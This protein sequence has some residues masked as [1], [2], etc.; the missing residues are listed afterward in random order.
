MRPFS[1]CPITIVLLS[2][3]QQLW[4]LEWSARLGKC[5]HHH[6]A[7]RSTK[8]RSGVETYLWLF[9]KAK[10]ITISGM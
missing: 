8:A 4:I 5:W 10:I 9:S 6:L 2:L 3:T 1:A 7:Y